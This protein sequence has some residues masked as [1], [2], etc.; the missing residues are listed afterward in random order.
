MIWYL[1]S[2]E[3]SSTFKVCIVFQSILIYM[4]FYDIF[5]KISKEPWG[6]PRICQNPN[7]YKISPRMFQA[8]IP[9][10]VWPSDIDQS[11][12][13]PSWP[14]LK[15]PWTQTKYTEWPF[16]TKLECTERPFW[17]SKAAWAEGPMWLWTISD[18]QT[19]YLRAPQ[20]EARLSTDLQE[21]LKKQIQMYPPPPSS[22]IIKGSKRCAFLGNLRKLCNVT[23]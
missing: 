21:N 19:L 2:Q 20:R 8:L 22:G 23:T 6:S 13:G 5:I 9:S 3:H 7:D 16:W 11:Q 1:P 14:Q 18:G 15:L 17:L 12:N 4:I 10:N